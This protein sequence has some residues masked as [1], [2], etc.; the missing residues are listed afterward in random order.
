M[1]YSPILIAHICAGPSGLLSHVEAMF[2][3]YGLSF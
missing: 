1:P 2:I 3:R